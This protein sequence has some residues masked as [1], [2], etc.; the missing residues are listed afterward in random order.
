[1]DTHDSIPAPRSLHRLPCARCGYQLEGIEVNTSD[2][3][4][5]PAGAAGWK[6]VCPECGHDNFGPPTYAAGK[7][8]FLRR[9]RWIG[10]ALAIVLVVAVFC[11]GRWL[12]WRLR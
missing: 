10:R 8:Q 9:W 1:M 6:A 5:R 2:A 3:D 11:L 4:D 12:F 7:A